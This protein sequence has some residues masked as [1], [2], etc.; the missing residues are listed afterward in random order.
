MNAN[1]K[2][3]FNALSEEALRIID[4]AKRALEAGQSTA[5]ARSELQELSRKLAELED[6]FEGYCRW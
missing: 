1:A 5:L 3:T 4:D 2:A 6:E